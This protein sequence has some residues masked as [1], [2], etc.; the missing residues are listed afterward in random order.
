M[1]RR[2]FIVGLGSAAVVTPA[3]A[4]TSAAPTIG[5]LDLN[6][7]QPKGPRLEA[8]RA[9]LED[10][11]FIEGKNLAIEY[12]WASRNLRLFP[13]L[14]ADLVRQQVAVIVTVGAL[15][16]ARSAK[17]ATST[18]PVVFVYGG[19]P[20]RDGLVESLNRPG[21]NL[22]GMTFISNELDGKRLDLLRQIVPH[23]KKVGFLSGP[24]SAFTYKEE[25]NSILA[26]GRALGLQILIAECSTERDYMPVMDSLVQN[27]AEAM[28]LGTYPFPNVNKIISLAAAFKIPTIYP[29][30]GSPQAGGLMSYGAVDSAA[31]RRVGKDYVARILKGARPAD[32]PVQQP[33][34]FAFAIN[35]KTAKALG[36]TIP[37]TLLATADE[38]ID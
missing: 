17:A 33:T 31:F 34:K 9:G 6:A 12:R 21:G 2:E 38:V 18:I 8:L 11:G 30:L 4:Q 35:L 15:G 5:Y 32:L 20:I 24:P 27:G 14:A 37:E 29:Y 1:R 22:T 23:A 19:D 25:K 16:P 7:P 28:T 26:A 3:G 13:T 36:L 10:A